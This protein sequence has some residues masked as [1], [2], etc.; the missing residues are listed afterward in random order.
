MPTEI[1]CEA[2]FPPSNGTLELE[3][4]VVGAIAQAYCLPGFRFPDGTL[5]K[6]LQ[7]VDQAGTDG[8]ANNI[9]MTWNDTLPA[10]CICMNNISPM[11]II[12][13]QFE[14]TVLL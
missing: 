5:K 11:C 2:L 13:R 10:A 4:V 12:C 9:T 6:T 7:C 14:N 1:Y 3:S 8:V